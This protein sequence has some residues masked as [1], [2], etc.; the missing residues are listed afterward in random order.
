[1]LSI[2]AVPIERTEYGQ[3]YGIEGKLVG[4][5]GKILSVRTIWM[6]ESA[7]GNTKFITMYPTREEENEV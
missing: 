2:D 1:M 6:T 3:M 4:P 7:T 5:N